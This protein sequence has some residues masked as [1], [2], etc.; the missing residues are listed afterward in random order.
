[1]HWV[2]EAVPLPKLKLLTEHTITRP[3]HLPLP[4]GVSQLCSAEFMRSRTI[5]GPSIPV[6][7]QSLHRPTRLSQTTFGLPGSVYHRKNG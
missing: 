3:S 7:A 4:N 2:I 1:M 5:R 6:E